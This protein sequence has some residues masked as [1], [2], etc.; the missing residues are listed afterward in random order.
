[1][2]E[3]PIKRT[4]PA[5]ACEAKIDGCFAGRVVNADRMKQW[6]IDRVA[7]EAVRRFKER[8]GVSQKVGVVE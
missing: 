7:E 2:A 5:P 3:L 4:S 8:Q 1:M 6:L